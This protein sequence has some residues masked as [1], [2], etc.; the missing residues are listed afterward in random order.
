MT[1]E[2]L[3]SP[4]PAVIASEGRPVSLIRCKSSAPPPSGEARGIGD[5]RARCDKCAQG[6]MRSRL[7]V[8]ASWLLSRELERLP[9]SQ[10]IER[11]PQGCGNGGRRRRYEVG[12]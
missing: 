7:V 11:R 10:R 3:G 1:R 2:T 8:L 9:R 5:L 12:R 4:S 6:S